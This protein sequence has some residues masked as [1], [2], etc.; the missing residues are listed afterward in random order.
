[1][2]KNLYTQAN[3]ILENFDFERVQKVM[4]FLDWKWGEPTVPS[5]EQIRSTANHMMQMAIS[6]SAR[7]PDRDTFVGTG[8]F[9]AHVYRF[10]GGDVLELN[11]SI[12]NYSGG[13]A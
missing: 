1:M 5:I 7:Q 6:E 10:N 3:Y 12:A 4:Q 2:R 9:C 11:F 13:V 8:G